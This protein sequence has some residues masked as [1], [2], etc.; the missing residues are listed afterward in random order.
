MVTI[1]TMVFIVLNPTT[2]ARRVLV[3]TTLSISFVTSWREKRAIQSVK[4]TI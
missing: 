2:T 3:I 1:S 4:T